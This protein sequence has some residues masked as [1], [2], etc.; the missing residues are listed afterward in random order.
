MA[1]LLQDCEDGI[2]R[3]S[4]PGQ[5]KTPIFKSIAVG[6]QVGI[7]MALSKRAAQVET[8]LRVGTY[9][10]KE[11]N[12]WAIE[13]LGVRLVESKRYRAGSRH[14]HF[15]SHLV[16]RV[17]EWDGVTTLFAK[18]GAGS[19]DDD[20]NNK[21]VEVSCS[22]R[23]THYLAQADAHGVQ[24]VGTKPIYTPRDAT[25]ASPNPDQLVPCACKLAFGESCD[26]CSGGA[27]SCSTNVV[28]YWTPE[29]LVRVCLATSSHRHHAFIHAPTGVAGNFNGDSWYWIE[30]ADGGALT[31][32]QKTN[33]GEGYEHPF[34]SWHYT[35]GC[36][37]FVDGSGYQ[38][39]ATIM[40]QKASMV[41][42]RF[43]AIAD[44]SVEKTN[45]PCDPQVLDAILLPMLTPWTTRFVCR[46]FG[47]SHGEPSHVL[48]PNVAVEA[49]EQSYDRNSLDARLSE[50]SG[51]RA[52]RPFHA[53][54]E[55][56][57]ATRG[58][59]AP[60]SSRHWLTAINRHL[61]K[62][63]YLMACPSI[64]WTCMKWFATSTFA[65]TVLYAGTTFCKWL[66]KAYNTPAET[67]PPTRCTPHGDGTPCWTGRAYVDR[68]IASGHVTVDDDGMAELTHLGEL[69][70]PADEPHFETEYSDNALNGSIFGK[71][72]FTIVV[73]AP[74]VEEHL[75]TYATAC[76]GALL[77][78][79]IAGAPG[80]LLRASLGF[81]F[82]LAEGA[83]R[84]RALA[85]SLIHACFGVMP[86]QLERVAAHMAWNF[87]CL[88]TRW[89]EEPSERES[90]AGVATEPSAMSSPA[91]KLAVD[92]KAVSRTFR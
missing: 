7:K 23:I 13:A 61:T 90:V 71:H 9:F 10:S 38:L 28:Y 25:R 84:G 3:H 65:S 22:S 34:R 50:Y 2:V 12:Y 79:P 70:H 77:G 16:R 92:D 54:V 1:D 81:L 57:F 4:W 26:N 6:A 88:E 66:W 27:V 73:L 60:R 68:L 44:P 43:E 37:V 69:E 41:E 55:N 15:R 30:A 72:P 17:I 52:A 24:L 51:T 35:G 56:Y 46:W 32:K 40:N 58:V 8:E 49:V 76:L 18:Y 45:A 11:D 42:I 19:G 33:G 83:I 62:E 75:K 20:E 86:T 21:V 78:A 89:T 67:L 29:Q 85:R 53:A 47:L 14:T 39:V 59:S 64:I 82:G 5:V 80:L 91:C 74:L 63:S 36:E 87:C 48:V 31:W